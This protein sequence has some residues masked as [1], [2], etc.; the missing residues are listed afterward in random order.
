MVMRSPLYSSIAL[1]LDQVIDPDVPT[2]CTD[3]QTIRYNPDFIGPLSFDELQGLIHHEALHV[4]YAHHLRRGERDPE[5]W[6]I[7]ADAVINAHAKEDGFSLPLGGVEIPEYGGLTTEQV[8]ARLE[9]LPRDHLEA[10]AAQLTGEVKDQTDEQGNP[11]AGEAL[12][13]AE[14][15]LERTLTIADSM[16]RKHGSGSRGAERILAEIRR[17]GSVNWRAE[18]AQWIRRRCR[19]GAREAVWSRPNRKVYSSVRVHVPTYQGFRPRVLVALDTSGSVG[20]GE[21]RQFAR[22][23]AGLLRTF[24]GIECYATSCDTAMS[25]PEKLRRPSHLARW[26]PKGGGGTDFSPVFEWAMRSDTPKVDAVV[27]FT[28]LYCPFP[29]P[30]PIPTL[31]AWSW[32]N[33]R[34]PPYG[35]PP[36]GKLLR[37]PPA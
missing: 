30:C 34:N 16:E 3:G 13:Q 21:V 31:W 4:A 6:N 28:D 18:L 33:D 36:F 11:L 25:E 12:S 27:Y 35:E 7:A 19:S 10:L 5:V 37:L 29:D 20:D 9:T 23:L 15:E 8:Y 17:Q 26:T 1:S 32:P 22:E 2:A 24:K 14:R